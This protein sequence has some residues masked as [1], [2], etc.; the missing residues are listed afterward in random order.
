MNPAET[1]HNGNVIKRN[2]T[3]E[4][5]AGLIAFLLGPDSTYV[6]GAV[7]GADGGWNC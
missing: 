4:E 6:S 7:Y 3:S 2:G 1:S 5:M